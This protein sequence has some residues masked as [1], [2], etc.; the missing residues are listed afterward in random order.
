MATVQSLF[1]VPPP[2]KRSSKKKIVGLV[3]LA[4]AAALALP[5]KTVNGFRNRLEAAMS[6]AVGRKVTVRNVHLRL[7]P[8]PGFELSG[9]AIQDDPAVSAEP[10]LRADSV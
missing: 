4:L 10:L 6:A 5:F 3:A 9:F 2:P 7:L 1:E 8:Q